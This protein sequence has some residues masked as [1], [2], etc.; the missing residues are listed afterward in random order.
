MMKKYAIV[1][2]VSFSM[3]MKNSKINMK[4]RRF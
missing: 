4:D 3:S 1:K 2:Y